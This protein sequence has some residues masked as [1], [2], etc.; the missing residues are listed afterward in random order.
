MTKGLAGQAGRSRPSDSSARRT[1]P[2]P[3][4][5]ASRRRPDSPRAL[6]RASSEWTVADAFRKPGTVLGDPRYNPV[7]RCLPG[8]LSRGFL[9][10]L[11]LRAEAHCAAHRGSP[12]GMET[13]AAASRGA[14]Y[15]ARRCR[16][17]AVFAPGAERRGDA[18]AGRDYRG[19][20]LG[21][22]AS[23]AGSG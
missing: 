22:G 6:G 14:C 11:D 10:P 1:L 15:R 8:W 19:A 5:P 23:L 21:A 7:L 17:L 16:W 9:S 13:W 4:E 18:A 20:R 12:L 2:L 3:A